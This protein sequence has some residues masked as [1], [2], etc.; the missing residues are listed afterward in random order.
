MPKAGDYVLV[1]G[2]VAGRIDEVKVEDGI[3]LYYIDRVGWLPEC[4][5]TAVPNMKVTIIPTDKPYYKDHYTGDIIPINDEDVP[6]PD[7]EEIGPY[8]TLDNYKALLNEIE[9]LY[10]RKNT[11]YGSSVD[12]TYLMFGETANLVRLWD[13]LL[14]LT[15]LHLSG[16]S[17]VKD[18]SY[19]DTKEDLANYAL[20]GCALQDT[21]T[22]NPEELGKVFS[23]FIHKAKNRRENNVK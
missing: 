8:T 3:K 22:G 7:P 19:R 20:I 2:R 13:K 1:G 23:E 15:Q 12:V 10:E 4:M 9:K 17:L 18:E 14:R 16:E 11:D 6:Q 5:I 21:Y